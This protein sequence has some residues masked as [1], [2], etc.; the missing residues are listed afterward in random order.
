[1][2]LKKIYNHLSELALDKNEKDFLNFAKLKKEKFRDNVLL[3]VP[4]DYYYV[5]YNY[6]LSKEKFR[7]NFMLM[8]LLNNYS[9]SYVSD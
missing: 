3:V 5:C 8:Q 7:H 1:M 9:H 4:N 6:L 2:I